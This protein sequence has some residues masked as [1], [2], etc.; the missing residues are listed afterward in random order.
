M[1]DFRLNRSAFKAHT[2]AEASNHAIYYQSLD[3]KERLAIAAYLNSIAFNHPLGAPPR[4]D[5]TKFVA[6]HREG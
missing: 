3:W 2:A 1:S 4:I 5:K 6:R